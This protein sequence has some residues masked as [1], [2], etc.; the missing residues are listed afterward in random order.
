MYSGA[1]VGGILLSSE[2]TVDEADDPEVL[3]VW[4]N[5]DSLSSG[6]HQHILISWSTSLHI[7]TEIRRH[8]PNPRRVAIYNDPPFYELNIEKMN[9]SE[10]IEMYPF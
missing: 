4:D 9:S 10:V 7:E 3:K 6:L 2:A 5:S 1:D 8:D